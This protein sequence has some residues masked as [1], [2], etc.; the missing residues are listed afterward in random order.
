MIVSLSLCNNLERLGPRLRRS[1]KPGRVY[2]VLGN[3]HGGA[4]AK[5]WIQCLMPKCAQNPWLGRSDDALADLV[6]IHVKPTRAIVE[7][8]RSI[9]VCEDY[10]ADGWWVRRIPPRLQLHGGVVRAVADPK[11]SLPPCFSL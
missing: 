8:M 6:H 9:S 7:D 10:C 2:R 11:H 3:G 4:I 1:G 5:K